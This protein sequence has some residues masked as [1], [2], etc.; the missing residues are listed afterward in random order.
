MNCS[1]VAGCPS[2]CGA[3]LQH[4]PYRGMD[5]LFITVLLLVPLFLTVVLSVPLFLTVV[6]LVPLFLTVV[7]LMPLFLTVVFLMP[8]FLTVVLEMPV[9][10]APCSTNCTFVVLENTAKVKPVLKRTQPNDSISSSALF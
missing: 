3:K 10:R 4:I 7:L 2:C 8:L 9:E 5:P 6:L 1:G